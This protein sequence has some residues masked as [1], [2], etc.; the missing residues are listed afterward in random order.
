MNRQEHVIIGIVIFSVF[1]WF[2]YQLVK[3][4]FDIIFFGLISTIV[5]SIIPDILEPSTN[6]MH[7]GIG[8][9]KRALKIT[10]EIFAITIVLSLLSFFNGIFFIFYIIA[11]FFL[12]YAFHLLADATT[13]VGLPD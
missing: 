4:P 12:G 1:S 13:A 3:V 5:G 11:S 8:H 9:S 6:W 10:G 7:R 2:L